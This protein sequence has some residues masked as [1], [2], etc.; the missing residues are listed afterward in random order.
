MIFVTVGTSEYPFD[1]LLKLADDALLKSGIRERVIAQIGPSTYR[2][3]YPNILIR[4]EIPYPEFSMRLRTARVIVTHGGMGTLLQCLLV[5]KH[6]PFTIPRD[7][8]Y[9]E[10]IND[11]QMRISEY[12]FRHGYCTTGSLLTYLARPKPFSG[13]INHASTLLKRLGPQVEEYMKG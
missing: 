8:K 13:R 10:H 6:L 9:H 5:A 1:R 3:R 2:F 12:F 4:K 11:H 7:P